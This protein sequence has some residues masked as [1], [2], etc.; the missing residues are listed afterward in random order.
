MPVLYA[1]TGQHVA[2][3][4]RSE[5]GQWSSTILLSDHG[6]QCIAVDPVNPDRLY[7]GTFDDGLYRSLDAGQ[8]WV[9]VDQAI[10]HDRFPSVAIS[11]SRITG[12]IHAVYAGTEP[13][14]LYVSHDDGESWT[15]LESLRSL[16]SAPTW[17]FPPR[18]WTSHVRWIALSYH[19]PDLIFAGIELG[20]VM[21]SIDGG[22]TWEDRKPGSYH[23]SHCIR[24]HPADSTR[25][26]EAAGGGVATSHDAGDTWKPE[27]EG[28]DRHYVWALAVDPTDP[29]RWFVSASHSARYAHRDDDSSEAVIYRR[30]GD[31]PWEPL[32]NGLDVPMAEMPY[33]LI[34]SEDQ[35]STVFAGT[36]QGSLL[37]SEDSGDS[38][39]TTGIELDGIQGLAAAPA[40]DR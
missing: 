12:G 17:S 9:R 1:A 18:P 15:D 38:W 6:V 2:R 8:S 34:I 11:P 3:L 20:G 10:P 27:D 13:S 22:V 7:A 21:R 37:V 35:P 5:D 26:Y 29:D 14:S 28:M 4:S 36:R 39:Q 25:I 24:T 31:A 23:D 30:I 19:D 33:A 40:S 32:S 16:P